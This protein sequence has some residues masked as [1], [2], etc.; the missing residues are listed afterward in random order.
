[1]AAMKFLSPLFS[2][3]LIFISAGIV[4]ASPLS[5]PIFYE[6]RAQ[7]INSAIKKANQAKKNNDIK[8]LCKQI[9]TAQSIIGAFRNGLEEY[10]PERNWMMLQKKLREKIIEYKCSNNWKVLDL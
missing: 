6:I 3:S 5:S 2:I 9:F 8:S 7:E 10:L 1:M 4:I